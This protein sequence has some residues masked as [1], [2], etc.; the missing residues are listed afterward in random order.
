MRLL[1]VLLAGVAG[2]AAQG[3]EQDAQAKLQQE[4]R[5][6]VEQFS[7]NLQNAMRPHGGPVS[8]TFPRLSNRACAIPLLKVRPDP[9]FKSNMP[10]IAPDPKIEFSAREV[11]PPA[12]VC[13][14][15]A[16]K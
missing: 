3:M 6:K 8:V 16:W 2:L 9:S 4:L 12:P 13:D 11:I 5:A 10:V 7:R 14:E 15:Q 1:I